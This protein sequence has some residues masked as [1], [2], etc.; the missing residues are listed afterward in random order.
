MSEKSKKLKYFLLKKYIAIPGKCRTRDKTNEKSDNWFSVL[1]V[2]KR[3]SNLAVEEE[4]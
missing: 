2:F 3:R 4:A 1:V